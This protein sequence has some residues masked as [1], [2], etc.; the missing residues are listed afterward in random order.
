MVGGSF[1]GKSAAGNLS[2]SNAT[3]PRVRASL[4]WNASG[5]YVKPSKITW[6][7]GTMNVGA[8]A[9]LDFPGNGSTAITGSYAGTIAVMHVVSDTATG[10]ACST[11]AGWTGF[12]FTGAHAASTFS[13]TS[14]TQPVCGSG[15]GHAAHYDSVVVFSFENRTW[16]DV[17]GAGFGK[18]M[19]YLHSLAQECAYFSDWTETDTSQNSLTQYTG[20][21]TG[22]R[23]AGTV[24][25]CAPSATC[26]TTADNIFRQ[27][28]AAGK[29]AIN[30][31]EGATSSCSASGNASKHIPDLYMW[32]ADDRANCAA[33]VRPYSE[34]NPNQLPNF[35]FITPTLC[36][37]GHD[38]SNATVDSWAR[39]NIDPV[40]KSA[41][42]KAGRVAV[43]VW[44]DED[45]PAPNVWITPTANPGA[46]AV[47][48]AGYKG[49][50]A[51]WESMLSLPC[52]ANACSATDMRGAAN[53]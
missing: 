6:S 29:T 41:A 52:L 3:L 8:S 23:Q 10:A 18:K 4:K 33:Q 1:K 50:L 13:A 12:G 16:T 36:H 42:Y 28:R 19:K 51:A 11:Q 2:C 35:A 48:G 5:G 17:G 43:F 34:F 45:H 24:D 46:H 20:Q 44:Y 31:V 39:T 27:A 32:G 38:C 25:D 14:A 15:A 9:G 21:V 26:S 30:Y 40:L 53:S 47:T 7:G 22:A 49:T 37:D